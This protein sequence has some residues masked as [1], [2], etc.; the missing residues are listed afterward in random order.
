MNIDLHRI[1]YSFVLSVLFISMISVTNAQEMK[2][3]L[4]RK[5]RESLLNS[6]MQRSNQQYPSQNNLHQN[7]DVL[8]V[9][10]TTKL[11]TKLNRFLIIDNVKENEIHINLNVTNSI[12]INMRPPGSVKYEFDGKKMHIRSN[13]GEMVK[14]SGYDF[15]PVRA[16]QRHKARK[17]QEKIDKILKAYGED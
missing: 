5:L 16:I 11:P 8:K 13:A 9:S 6:K 1:S 17:R 2:N 4:K 14:P 7:Q 15:D 3:E 12:P 10:P